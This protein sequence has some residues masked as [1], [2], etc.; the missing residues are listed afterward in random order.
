MTGEIVPAD[1]ESEGA[2]IAAA[3]VDSAQLPAL[4][5]MLSAADFLDRS[6][7][8][9]W[10]AVMELFVG[11]EQVNAITV[12]YALAGRPLG[13]HAGDRSQLDEFGG[14]TRMHELIG[15]LPSA[16]GAAW[17][18]GNVVRASRKRR[19]LRVAHDLQRRAF[20]L[21]SDPDE[22]ADH[23]VERLLAL[24]KER[25]KALV[26]RAQAVI[27][28]R[29][30]DALELWAEDPSLLPGVPMGYRG[31][32]LALGGLA[33]GRMSVVLADTG[34][35]KSVFVQNVA[36]RFAGAGVAVLMFTTEM[37]ASE[38]VKRLVFQRAAFDSVAVTRRG[39]ILTGERERMRTGLQH[40]ADL[41]LWV[42]D[43]G[44]VPLATVLAETRRLLHSQPLGLVVVDHMQALR[45]DGQNRAQQLEAIA[46][47]LKAM[48]QDLEVHVMAVS[49]I[50]RASQREGSVNHYSA[51]E[52][53]GIEQYAD[54][55]LALQPGRDVPGDGW[56]P[57]SKPQVAAAVRDNGYVD[58]RVGIAKNR[59][60][61]EGSSVL[62]LDWSRGGQFV[63]VGA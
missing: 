8:W 48:A 52:S 59:H 31:L 61:A 26:E 28:D 40:V 29:A 54:A 25:P 46:S 51:K 11:G 57:L 20:D 4:A 50:N 17:Y 60:G 14:Q 15:A 37:S 12:A 6:L 43:A 18:A 13:G 62:R 58:V 19:L 63:E 32:D 33:P 53:S 2:V 1:A 24:G 27:L 7:G 22:D 36:A 47:G 39:S 5:S 35:G 41:P 55:I 42:C 3:L 30:G 49:H 44:N 9:A 21:A 38:V 16:E 45:A 23:A 56:Q 34:I 10:E